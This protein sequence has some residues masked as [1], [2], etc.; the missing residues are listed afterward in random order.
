MGT[1]QERKE[2]IMKTS[3]SSHV[4]LALSTRHAHLRN[5]SSRTVAAAFLL[6]FIFGPASGLASDGA[7]LWGDSGIKMAEEVSPHSVWNGGIV[8]DGNGGAI[9]LWTECLDS[10]PASYS[11]MLVAQRINYNGSKLWASPNYVSARATCHEPVVVADGSGGVLVAWYTG[12]LVPDG[13]Y[14]QRL[15]MNGAQQWGGLGLQVGTALGTAGGPRIAP[16]KIGGAFVGWAHRL[17]HIQAAGTLDYPGLDGIEL[18]PGSEQNSYKM[19]SDG[20]GGTFPTPV[21]GGVFAAWSTLSGQLVAQRA[22]SG[23]QWGSPGLVVATHGAVLGYDLA[24]DG[25]GGIVL[26]WVATDGAYPYRYTLR[27]Q[28]LDVNGNKLWTSGGVILMDSDVVTG[29]YEPP[30]Y[31][32]PVI[33]SDSSGG[34]IIAWRDSRNYHAST[35]PGSSGNWND[36]YAQR[37]D[38]NGALLWNPTGVLLPPYIVG[39][40]APG[41]QGTPNIVSDTCNGAVVAYD[42]NGGW[43]WDI[44]GTRLNAAGTK[45]WSE[46]IRFDGTSSS[47]PGLPQRATAIAFDGSGPV[48]TGAVLVWD[49]SATVGGHHRVYAQKVQVDLTTPVLPETL[50]TCSGASGDFYDRGFYITQYPGVSLS[51][52][53]LKLSAFQTAGSYVLTLTVRSNTYGGP[54][55]ATSTATATLSG[56]INENQPVTFT[57]PSVPVAKYSRVCFILSLVSGPG[58]SVYYAVPPS[59]GC[60]GIVQT[61]GTTP[62]LDFWRRDGVDLILTGVKDAGSDLRAMMARQPTGLYL[63]WNSIGGRTYT[64]EK[65]DNPGAFD[66]LQTGITATP[67]TNSFGPLTASPSGRQFYRVALEPT[68]V[69]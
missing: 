58:T 4:C 12:Q 11:A 9:V 15:N 48:P 62:P 1:Q 61:E 3:A 34:A 20:T 44:A 27:A 24:R 6:T 56:S 30:D 2:V 35:P 41:D 22:H 7:S 66:A 36:L 17:T 26:C 40:V 50:L 33:T 68:P 60:P 25:A 45:L 51:S 29:S 64:V 53:Q 47:N 52:V 28:R 42:D 69:P 23:L 49:E 21:P 57:F 38:A 46:W 67:P 32:E 54:V 43:N 19:I 14:A 59:P 8:S 10:A 16:D 13:I 5:I 55:L 63:Q 37:L 18:I 31:S 39:Q 65:S